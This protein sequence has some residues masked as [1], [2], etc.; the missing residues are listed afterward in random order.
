MIPLSGWAYMATWVL[1]RLIL[2]LVFLLGLLPSFVFG[3]QFVP[4]KDAW[5]QRALWTLFLA[6]AFVHYLVII[7]LYSPFTVFLIFLGLGIWNHWYAI[8][9]DLRGGI[10]VSYSTLLGDLADRR[11]K[12]REVLNIHRGSFWKSLFKRKFSDYLGVG[13][14]VVVISVATWMRFTRP[15]LHAAPPYSD[16]PIVL[17]WSKYLGMQ[18]LYHNK[19]YPRGQMALLSLLSGLTGVNMIA[20]M[21]LMGPIF[22]LGIVLSLMYFI[23]R[24]TRSY[25]AASLAGLTFGTLPFLLGE[26][27]PRYISAL[28]QEFGIL[29]IFPAVW[30]AYRYLKEGNDGDLRACA[31]AMGLMVF[32]HPLGV[33]VSLLAITGLGF[34]TLLT[35]YSSTLMHRAWVLVQWFAL[36][37]AVALAPMAYAILKGEAWHG[38]STSFLV[39]S[40]YVTPK[41]PLVSLV[42]L[43]VLAVGL[44]SDLIWQWLT[45]KHSYHGLRLT[46]LA[47]SGLAFMAQQMAPWLGLHSLVFVIRGPEFASLATGLAVGL[48]W[49]NFEIIFGQFKDW[50]MP[51]AMVLGVYLWTLN[52]PVALNTSFH[53]GGFRSETVYQFLRMNASHRPFTWTLVSDSSGYSLALGSAFQMLPQNFLK[54]VQELPA[55][56]KK[57]LKFAAKNKLGVSQS[58]LF[59]V[60]KRM[61]ISGFRARIHN[62]LLQAS[63]LQHWL[64]V[65]QK[66]YGISEVY[67]G[68]EISAWRMNVPTLIRKGVV[69]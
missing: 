14:M 34:V 22:G 17:A 19:I 67:N 6:I 51:L 30:F 64:I 23:L 33:L 60:D 44:V 32:I 2:A 8:P 62:E 59:I 43:G 24:T 16:E 31:A 37:A 26:S 50:L 15:F 39:A 54:L 13:M 40:S 12:F 61:K 46:V 21:T 55:N 27:G 63:R 58:Y 36:V 5:L 3:K 42:T 41:L 7:H 38:A 9:Q 11:L 10:F 18:I 57:W 45:H 52:T 68:P 20:V 65:H 48:G 49:A 35:L 53:F 25:A 47:V 69:S 29:F 56:N 4:M 28:S 66:E 1:I